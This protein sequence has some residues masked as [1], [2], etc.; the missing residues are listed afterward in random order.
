MKR[1]K[2]NIIKFL[3]QKEVSKLFKTIEKSKDTNKYWLRDLTL[4]NIVYIGGLRASEPCLLK[5]EHYNPNTKEIF[6]TRQK[7][8]ISNTIRIG[9]KKA[10][11]INKYI[12]E[13]NIKKEDFL[14]LTKSKKPL[15]RKTMEYLMK[16][17]CTLSKIPKEKSHCHILKHSIA[18]HLLASGADILELQQYLGHKNINSSVAYTHFSTSHQNNFYKKLDLSKIA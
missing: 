14:F 4:F 1:K 7:G 10:K 8:S 12:R 11:L 3:T 17:Y 6:T 18:V 9:D 16:K 15:E 5:K 13:Y 2:E